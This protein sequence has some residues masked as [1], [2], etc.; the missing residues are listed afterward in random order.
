MRYGVFTTNKDWAKSW[1][2]TQ[3]YFAQM[4]GVTVD[5]HRNSANE[6]MYY[7]NNGDLY[8][9]VR[10]SENSRGIRLDE[11]VV[12]IST[13]PLEIITNI[14][15]HI[16]K[17]RKDIVIAESKSDERTLFSFIEQLK[18]VA[19]IKGD[20]PIYYDGYDVTDRIMK[21][22]SYCGDITLGG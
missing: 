16:V 5:K 18:K 11:A 2:D 12:D 3:R 13:C 20:M 17:H 7:M 19:A 21:I 1:I 9:W 6:L 22:D 4:K 14:I 8:M 10:P 15:I